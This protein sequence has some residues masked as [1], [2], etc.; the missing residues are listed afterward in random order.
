MKIDNSGRV[1][2]QFSDDLI[3]PSDLSKIDFM[4]LNIEII[5]S[6]EVDSDNLKFTWSVTAFGRNYLIIQLIFKD[7]LFVSSTGPSLREKLKIECFNP[8]FF[9]RIID[10][11]VIPQ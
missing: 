3:I 7:P 10:N 5:E 2:I 1:K 11:E 9:V 8:K 6:G 4:V